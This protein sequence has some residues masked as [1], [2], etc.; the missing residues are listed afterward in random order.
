MLKRI[1]TIL[2][3]ISLSIF[4]M[5][6]RFGYVDTEYVLNSLPQYAS[7][8]EKVNAQAENWAKEIANYE[9]ELNRE[10]IEYEGEKVLLTKEQIEQRE[11]GIEEKRNKISDLKEQRYGPTGDLISLRRN[12]VKPIQDQVWN[13]VK[14]VAERRKYSFIF[15]KGSDL[16]MIYSDPKY[17][18]SEEVLKKLLGD[19]E[20]PVRAGKDIQNQRKEKINRNIKN[21]RIN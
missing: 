19:K 3:F 5:A 21:R 12:L 1:L 9:N 7:A 4:T 15:D 8:Q 11:K 17:D 2:V 6:Q 18:I 14:Q 13:T 20:K 16:I 10:L